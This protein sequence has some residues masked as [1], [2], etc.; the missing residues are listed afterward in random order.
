MGQEQAPHH[1][2]LQGSQLQIMAQPPYVSIHQLLQVMLPHHVSSQAPSIPEGLGLGAELSRLPGPRQGS[3]LEGR[4]AAFPETLGP[5]ELG[6]HGAL[7]TE[8][9]PDLRRKERDRRRA[10]VKPLLLEAMVAL[11][12]T[13][14][15]AA[16]IHQ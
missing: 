15:R 4:A 5:A 14:A 12:A 9:R 16:V 8:S 6:A 2:G 3:A 10:A 11:A 13:A 7:K 1:P